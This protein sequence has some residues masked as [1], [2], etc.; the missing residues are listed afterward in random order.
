[1]KTATKPEI[2]YAETR[3][4]VRAKQQDAAWYV[5][6]YGHTWAATVTVN[7]NE[8]HIYADGEMR[9]H[10]YPLDRDLRE[11]GD[12]LDAGLNSDY[13]L[14]RAQRAGKIEWINN[15]WFD[16]YDNGGHHLDCV[17]DHLDFAVKMATELL[18]QYPNKGDNQ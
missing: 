16:L 15:P 9:I 17:C 8:I 6:G 14:A 12:L 10:S 11:A 18:N 5:D 7:G 13:D 1:M 4:K 2:T 3:T